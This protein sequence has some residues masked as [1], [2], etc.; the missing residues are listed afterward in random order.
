[1]KHGNA[2]ALMVKSPL[3]NSPLNNPETDPYKNHSY[4]YSGSM[5]G[6]ISNKN[7]QNELA[8]KRASNPDGYFSQ[9]QDGKEILYDKGLYG[10]NEKGHLTFH[11]NTHT[12]RD[13]KIVKKELNVPKPRTEIVKKEEPVVK[14]KPAT[15]PAPKGGGSIDLNKYKGGG[16]Q[17]QNFG[18]NP[19][20]ITIGH[21]PRTAKGDLTLQKGDN[22]MV[23]KS[24]SN[25][26]GSAN[27]LKISSTKPGGGSTNSSSLIPK[28]GFGGGK[29]NVSGR[30]DFAKTNEMLENS[31]KPKAN[32]PKPKSTSKP[33]AE[34]KQ[35]IQKMVPKPATEI[36]VKAPE[37][38]KIETTIKNAMDPSHKLVESGRVGR[39]RRRQEKRTANVKRRQEIKR[40]ETP[41]NRD[42]IKTIR[43][44]NRQERKDLKQDMPVDKDATGGRFK[45]D[46]ATKKLVKKSN[47]DSKALNKA[48]AKEKPASNKPSAGYSASQKS[49]QN[50][51]KNTFET[52]KQ[53]K[54]N[55][56]T[57]NPV[58]KDATGGRASSSGT[59]DYSQSS[60][61][62][63]KKYKKKTK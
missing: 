1:M 5:A 61:A 18:K 50:D 54:K 51:M 6:T 40:G 49:F 20:N 27:D 23:N 34:K 32:S 12:R 24:Y 41:S 63:K 35:E 38:T 36:E 62:L 15:T 21:G 58:D 43:E 13:G 9:V 10:Q 8:K 31:L 25:N 29:L 14:E 26:I 57:D 53:E 44:T 45:T 28:G 52:P 55:L 22:D 39:V 60:K 42:K 59:F 3:Y 56:L 17:V 37:T 2:A 33:K 16:L 11:E 48:K 47:K 7:Y 4:D 19:E 30:P 46:K